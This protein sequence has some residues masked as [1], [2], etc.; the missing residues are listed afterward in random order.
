MEYDCTTRG[1]IGKVLKVD[2]WVEEGKFKE[3]VSLWGCT[4]CDSTS[5]TIWDGY[6][7]YALDTKVCE[8]DCNCFG[9]KIKT[10]QMNAGDATRDISDK[11]WTSELKAYKDARAQGIQPSSTNRRDIEAAH[12]ASETLGVAYN[13]ETMQRAQTVTSGT[14]EILK[15]TGVI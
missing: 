3:N 13:G 15:E 7:Q 4:K 10:L 8:A 6:G 5:S 12:K 2:Y 14:K 9:C 1:H 11:K